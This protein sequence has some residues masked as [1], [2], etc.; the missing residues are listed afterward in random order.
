MVKVLITRKYGKDQAIMLRP[1]LNDLYVKVNLHQGFISAESLVNQ[2]DPTEHLIISKWNSIEEW[3]AYN[4]SEDIQSFRNM[5][6]QVLGQQTSRQ[7]Y[8]QEN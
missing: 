5:I 1:L 3:T 2:Q 8:I 7:V 6:D 4:E